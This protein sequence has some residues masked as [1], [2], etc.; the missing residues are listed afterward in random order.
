[1]LNQKI[2]YFIDVMMV[3]LFLVVAKSGIVLYFFLPE[4]QRRAGWQS[5]F[6]IA[7]HTWKDIHE[8]SGILMIALIFLHII[9]HL[10]WLLEMTKNILKR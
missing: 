1:M 3:F 8:L 9:L 5:F 2:N 6:G 10:K 4:G 7:R